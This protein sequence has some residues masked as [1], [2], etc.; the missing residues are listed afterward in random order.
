VEAEQSLGQYQAKKEGGTGR[1]KEA[2][3]GVERGIGE[4]VASVEK[5]C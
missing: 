3:I 1:G 5:V 4:E 2:K